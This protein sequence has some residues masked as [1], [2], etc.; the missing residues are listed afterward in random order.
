[1][2]DPKKVSRILLGKAGIRSALTPDARPRGAE[3]N[4]GRHP[5]EWNNRE[6]PHPPWSSKDVQRVQ[7]DKP[8][9]A[10]TPR[11]RFS[12]RRRGSITHPRSRQLPGP[13]ETQLSLSVKRS[14]ILRRPASSTEE[15]THRQTCHQLQDKSLTAVSRRHDLTRL[16]PETQ[17][18]RTGQNPDT[19]TPNTCCYKFNKVNNNDMV[20]FN[21]KLNLKH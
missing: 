15:W 5:F 14:D 19:R 18:C 9:A 3:I 6:T 11:R 17:G 13:T 2:C 10:A 7:T 1:M 4:L 12:N 20:L 21:L 16:S 8:P